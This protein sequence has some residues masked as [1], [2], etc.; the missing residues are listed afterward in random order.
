MRHIRLHVLCAFFAVCS[1]RADVR[2]PAL[3]SDHMVLQQG[4]PVRIWGGAAAGE[5]VRVAFQGQ[6]VSTAASPD[7]AWSVWVPPLAPGAPADLTV[8]GANTVVVHDVLVGD[9]WVGSGQSNM[10]MPVSRVNQAE[11][12]IARADYPRIRLFQV[13][14]AL[15]ERPAVDVEGPG[16]S[17]LPNPCAAFPP[18]PTSSDATSTSGATCPSG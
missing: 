14:R 16:N 10:E 12:E 3:L 15:A 5:A 7:G 11:E 1:A 17:A 2:L 9:V 13:K 8:A 6:S 18:W 4:M